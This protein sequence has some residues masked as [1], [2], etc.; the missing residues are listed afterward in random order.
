MFYVVYSDH[1]FKKIFLNVLF[2]RG[3]FPLARLKLWFIFLVPFI[4]EKRL[5]KL[6]STNDLNIS[7]YYTIYFPFFVLLEEV[8]S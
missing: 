1:L 3:F 5:L 2:G 4:Y 7:I 8:G 6:F